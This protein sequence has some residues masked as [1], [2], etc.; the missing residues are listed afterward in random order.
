[1]KNKEQLLKD[2]PGYFKNYPKQEI[3]FATEDGQFFPQE[4]SARSHCARSKKKIKYFEILRSEVT[5]EDKEN[6]QIPEGNPGEEWT[7]PQIQAWLDKR[8]VKYGNN[9]KEANLLAKVTEFLEAEK[10]PK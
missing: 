1:M 8:D 10:D 7:I 9:A 6:V 5:A 3:F 4:T 2:A